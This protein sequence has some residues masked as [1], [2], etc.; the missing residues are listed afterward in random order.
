MKQEVSSLLKDIIADELGLDGD[1]VVPSAR[2]A[3]DLTADSL[4][5][6]ELAIRLEEEF[7]ISIPDD[8]CEKFTTVQSTIDYIEKKVTR[9]K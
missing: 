6:A 2:F 7:G 1:E 8:D 4:D 5:I 3:Q 9:K